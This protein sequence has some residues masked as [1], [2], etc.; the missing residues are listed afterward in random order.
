MGLTGIVEALGYANANLL[1][2]NRTPLFCQP[3]HL[4]ISVGQ[5]IEMLQGWVREKNAIVRRAVD[6]LPVAT[7]TATRSATSSAAKIVSW[8]NRPC[9]QRHSILTFSP[10]SKMR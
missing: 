2:N 6:N 5:Y 1:A 7:I 9:A 3:Q 4:T 8:S 10:M